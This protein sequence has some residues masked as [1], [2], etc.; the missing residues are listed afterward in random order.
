MY[1]VI[2]CIGGAMAGAYIGLTGVTGYQSSGMGIFTIAATLST[3]DGGYSTIHYCIAIVIAVAV[4]LITTLML[5]EDN[6]YPQLLHS[7]YTKDKVSLKYVI[8]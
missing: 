6:Q 8:I 1:F 7:G 5:Y 2:S 4:P 3:K